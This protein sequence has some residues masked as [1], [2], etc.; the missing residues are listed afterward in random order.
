MSPGSGTFESA[1][2]TAV[3][4]EWKRIIA[5]NRINSDL[6]ITAMPAEM[7][8]V[9]FEK[10]GRNPFNEKPSGAIPRPLILKGLVIWAWAV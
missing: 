3:G 6:T 4:I 8:C 5:V 10:R 2:D 1:G 9:A 7:G